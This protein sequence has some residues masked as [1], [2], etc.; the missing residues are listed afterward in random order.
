MQADLALH[1]PQNKVMVTHKGE[2]SNASRHLT[3]HFVD[4]CTQNKVLYM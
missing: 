1:S 4:F 3:L 2:I